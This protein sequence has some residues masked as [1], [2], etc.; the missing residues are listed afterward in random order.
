MSLDIRDGGVKTLWK[1]SLPLILSFLSMLGMLTVDRLF[2]AK[3]SAEAL[4][5]AVSGG[6]AAWALTFGGQTLTNISGIYVA[7]YNGSGEY[8]KI[9]R[10]VWQMIWLSLAF[11]LPFGAAA[12]WF[13]P[14]AFAGSPIESEQILYYR[15]TMA[16]SPMMCMLGGLNGFFIGR[17]NTYIITWLTL[18]GNLVNL[19]LDPLLIFGWGFIPSLGIAGACIA[20]GIGLLSQLVIMLFIFL[21]SENRTSFGTG[22]Y[23]LHWKTLRDMIKIGS[24][25]ALG[26]TLELGAWAAFYCLLSGLSSVHI[27]VTS[28]GQSMLMAFFFFG[29]GLEQ[30]ISSVCGNLIGAKLKDEVVTAFRSGLKI[31]ALFGVGLMI[32]MVAGGD[33]IVDLFLKN[34]DTL[35]G[36]ERISSLSSEE[37]ALA[38]EYVLKSC[39]VIGAYIIIENVRCLLYGILRAAGDTFFIL[40]LSVASTWSLLLAPTYLLM[41]LWKMPV[42]TSFWIWLSFATITTLACYMRFAGGGW[43]NR[44][45]ISP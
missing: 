12:L 2:L 39:L 21:K 13:A 42:D 24:P 23:F 44:V 33:W 4:S 25:E 27:L 16:I 9:G 17:G 28:V 43:R 41:T 3:Y 18:L 38:R 5:A 26:A 37:L 45:I 36:G 7:Q 31:V 1:I 15:W 20:T 22:D 29:I 14:F 11:I 34:P 40:L 30:G 19:A 6:M 35:E 32:V 8:Q 10:P